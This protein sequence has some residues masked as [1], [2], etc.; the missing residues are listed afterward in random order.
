MSLLQGSLLRL[1]NTAAYHTDV[2]DDQM[3]RELDRFADRWEDVARA[4]A[5]PNKEHQEA[6]ETDRQTR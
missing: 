1:L 2:P 4:D 3:R 6:G 5:G